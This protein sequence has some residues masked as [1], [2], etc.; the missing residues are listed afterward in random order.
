MAFTALRAVGLAHARLGD[1]AVGI[2][3]VHRALAVAEA[4]GDLVAQAHTHNALCLLW[5]EQDAAEK[6]IAHAEQA[7]ELFRHTGMDYHQINEANA[8]AALAWYHARAEHYSEARELAEAAC[9]LYRL[10]DDRDGEASA[11]D[12]LA[13]IAHRTGH[14][15]QAIEY[16]HQALALFRE[17]GNTSQ[18]AD[19]LERLGDTY[20]SLGRLNQARQAWNRSLTHYRGRHQ[21]TAA[22]HIQQKLNTL[23]SQ[24]DGE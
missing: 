17:A 6:V 1:H 23:L 4:A 11:T 5:N 2:E 18:E 13:L 7:L 20:R 24:P 22:E 14:S 19:T 12:T 10:H 15:E 8:L 21:N 9:A 16:Y 3:H